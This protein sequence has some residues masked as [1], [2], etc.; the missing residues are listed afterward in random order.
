MVKSAS[1]LYLIGQIFFT[2]TV[3]AVSKD[4]LYNWFKGLEP[5][6][7]VYAVN[8]GAE[9][10]FTDQAGIKYLADTDFI[11]GVASNEGEN[12]RWVMPNTQVYY[13]ERWGEEDF[14]YK[15]PIDQYS[16]AEYTLVLK[17][18]E[19]YFSEPY[20]KVFNVAVGDVTIIRDL[21]IWGKCGAKLLPH[22]EFISLKTQRGELFVNGQKAKDGISSDG[23]LYI[24]FQKGKADNPKVNAILLVRGGADNTHV[25]NFNAYKQTLIDIQ[26]EKEAERLKAEAFFQ[27][28]AY[29]Y[30]ERIDGQGI[31]NNFLATPYALEAT[32]SLF[33][34]G[35]FN[36]IPE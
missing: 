4:P 16:D 36:S 14:F 18:A 3:K 24:R 5:E 21:D 11:G 29:D 33:M 17:F 23:S 1:I 32:I 8:C 12:Y 28:D 22:D 6:N 2:Q 25:N 27:E 15:V 30:D 19:V 10:P 13:S 34:I 26:K 9:E 31:F 20:M 35:F 7:V